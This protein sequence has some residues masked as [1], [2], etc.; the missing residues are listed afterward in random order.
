MS[1]R[2]S[3]P[4]T[5]AAGGKPLERFHDRYPGPALPVPV[6]EIAEDLL[7][8]VVDENDSLAVSGMLVP[9]ERHILLNGR[10][11]RQSEGRRRF[12]LAHELGHWVCQFQAGTHRAPVLPLRGDRVGG[13][14]GARAGGERL[15][16][17]SAHARGS[18][19]LGGRVR[20]SSTSMP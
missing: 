7:G 10:E 13:G 18:R 17:R 1:A 16:R 3:N 5:A 14:Q 15:R 20:C 6:D 4:N 9:A 2:K 19:P 12:T 8:L 11:S